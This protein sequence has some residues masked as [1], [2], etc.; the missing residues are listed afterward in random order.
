MPFDNSDNSNNNIPNN[1]LASNEKE[2]FESIRKIQSVYGRFI[3]I[4][5]YIVVVFILLSIAIIWYLFNTQTL[6]IYLNSMDISSII[7]FSQ[8]SNEIQII[9]SNFTCSLIEKSSFSLEKFTILI[10]FITGFVIYT[11]FFGILGERSRP[12]IWDYEERKK[13]FWF[14]E[15]LAIITVI[16][17]IFILGLIFLGMIETNRPVE[18]SF[19]AI[20]W[21]NII[22]IA[23]IAKNFTETFKKY[24]DFAVYSYMVEN[25]EKWNKTLKWTNIEKWKTANRPDML[26]TR[27]ISGISGFIFLIT[28]ELAFI[29]FI[30]NFNILFTIFV[31]ITFLTF[32]IW[33]SKMT[34]LP[35][36]MT[37]IE[38]VSREILKD[39]F[40]LQ[41]ISNEFVIVQTKEDIRERIPMSS[42]NKIIFHDS[43]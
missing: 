36:N 8:S 35:T 9:C 1:V 32:H 24:R 4:L 6:D 15:N 10:T 41:D 23:P 27:L 22:I 5:F 29:G 16:Y 40:I 14:F 37:N 12:M 11:Y 18:F 39:V 17:T 20:A 34:F 33:A 42:I 25:F 30:I 43:V 7:G 26:N 21:I 19:I 13:Y 2:Y 3:L 38:L 28:L 31:I